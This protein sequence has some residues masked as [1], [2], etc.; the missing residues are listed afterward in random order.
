M[1]YEEALDIYPQLGHFNANT[2][3][4]IKYGILLSQ[5]SPDFKK[6]LEVVIEHMEKALKDE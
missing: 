4:M 6:S 1:T 3:N 2:L 5:N